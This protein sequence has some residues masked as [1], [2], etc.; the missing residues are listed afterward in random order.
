MLKYA[1]ED[2]HYLLYIY[3]NMRKDLIEKGQ[4]SSSHNPFQFIRLSQYKSNLIC[5]K[6]YEK[7]ILKD[8][9]FYMMIARNKQL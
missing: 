6:Q 3:D 2:T 9:N 7:P 1:R 4:K 5:L 8:Y